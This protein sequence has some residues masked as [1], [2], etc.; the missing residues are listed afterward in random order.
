CH[1]SCSECRGPTQQ[2]CLSCSDPAASLKDGVCVFDCGAGYY[3][4]EGICYACDSSCASCFPDNP[5]CMSCPTGTALHHGKCITQCP[6]QHYVDNHS[7]CRACHSSCATCW[8]PSVSQCISCPS[9]LLLHQGQC[10]ETCGEG[11][12]PQDSTCHN[13]HPSCRS[14]VGPLASDCLR[15]LKPEEVLLPQHIHLRHGICTSGCPEHSFLDNLQT[16]RDCH[17]SCQHCTGPSAENCSSCLSPSSLFEGRCV[18][19]CPQGFF[20]QDNQCQACHP[21]CQTCSGPSQADCASCP[22]QASL[23][24]GYCTT[25]CQEGRFLSAVTGECLSKSAFSAARFN[26]PFS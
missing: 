4:Q 24:S 8:G 21:S 17:P 14:C 11:L 2:E 9:G 16:C 25:G 6:T 23:Q 20:T 13:C 10:V 26:V 18:P 7:R 1:G 15:C 19:T 3:N 5:K 12:Y 22:P